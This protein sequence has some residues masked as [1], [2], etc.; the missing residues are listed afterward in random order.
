M[1]IYILNAARKQGMAQTPGSLHSPMVH[2][3]AG[4]WAWGLLPQQLLC[5][6]DWFHIAMR[7]QNL[8]SAVEEADKETERVKWTLWHGKSEECF[9]QTENPDDKRHRRQETLKTRKKHDY[10]KKTIKACRW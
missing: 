2:S 10:L 5:I 8:R 7:F 3:I 1:K 4:L 6:L 9:E